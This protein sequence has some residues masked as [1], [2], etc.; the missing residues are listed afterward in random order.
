MPPTRRDRIRPRVA[1]AADETLDWLVRQRAW[2]LR[3]AQLE[4]ATPTSLATLPAPSMAGSPAGHLVTDHEE[5]AEPAV[6]PDQLR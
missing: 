4:G 5:P 1:G 6:V 2:E 3:L